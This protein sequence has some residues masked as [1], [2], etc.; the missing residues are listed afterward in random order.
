MRLEK[1]YICSSTV[2]P[3]HGIEFV[4]NDAKVFRFCRSK[5]RKTFH[6]KR[7]PR[8]LRW[9]KAYRKSHG[10]EMAIDSTFE[11]ERKRQ[12]IQRYDR[13]LVGRTIQAIQKVDAVR[14]KR[15][16]D[17]YKNRMKQAN[18]QVQ[19]TAVRELEK[20]ISLIEPDILRMNEAV[21]ARETVQQGVA[22]VE[23]DQLSGSN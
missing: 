16:K 17:Y 21:K 1:C 6:M 4:R 7:N 10:K 12:R 13:E 11:F 15:E 23:R 5:C 8:Y 18:K 20:G 22:M 19:K 3:G 2:Y 14:M 9:T